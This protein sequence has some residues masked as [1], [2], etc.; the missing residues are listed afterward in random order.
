MLRIK[1]EYEVEDD[2]WVKDHDYV[3]DPDQWAKEM[4]EKAINYRII[5]IT[6][7]V[8]NKPSVSKLA[9]MLNS[10]EIDPEYLAGY[11]LLVLTE[12]QAKEILEG[13]ED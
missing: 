8:D 11:C 1:Y 4:A 6:T 5:S 3:D 12:E 13:M 10:K 7:V 2:Y 9:R